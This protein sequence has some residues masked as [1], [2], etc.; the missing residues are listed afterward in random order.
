MPQK[1]VTERRVINLT[2][3]DAPGP[4]IF[5]TEAEPKM[6]G[7]VSLRRD[8]SG[9]FVRLA[10]PGVCRQ[11]IA[12]ILH[13]GLTQLL[14]TWRDALVNEHD[15]QTASVNQELR[16]DMQ[17]FLNRFVDVANANERLTGLGII[18]KPQPGFSFEAT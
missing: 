16:S 2:D 15:G 18:L 8:R 10:L 7:A 14:A 3:R 4:L 5:P 12:A 6:V 11:F 9:A 1:P 13:E 17:Q